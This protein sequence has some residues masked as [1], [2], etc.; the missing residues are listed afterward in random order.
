MKPTREVR[1]LVDLGVQDVGSASIRSRRQEAQPEA[2]PGGGETITTCPHAGGAKNW[3][4]E[5]KHRNKVLFVS[6]VEACMD[7]TPVA[8]GA[9]AACDGRPVTLRPRPD[10]DGK[11]AACS[12]QPRDEED[13]VETRQRPAVKRGAATAAA[14]S[15]RAPLDRVFAATTMHG[16]ECGGCAS[17]TCRIPPGPSATR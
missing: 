11:Y 14:W 17:T 6:L 7:L 13:R 12:Q 15:S 16:R 4:P 8:A 9:V 5:S 2:D 3:M 10:S 1:F